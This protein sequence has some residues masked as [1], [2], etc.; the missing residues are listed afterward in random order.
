MSTDRGAPAPAPCPCCGASEGV[1]WERVAW[2][3]VAWI[4]ALHVSEPE[5]AELLIRRC[6]QRAG[7]DA[8][9]W[10]LAAETVRAAGMSRVEEREGGGARRRA[11][12]EELRAWKPQRTEAQG[13]A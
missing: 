2:M 7:V 3:R 6:G 4:I 12:L 5:E 8:A 10:L 13:A 9:K 11:E 1:G